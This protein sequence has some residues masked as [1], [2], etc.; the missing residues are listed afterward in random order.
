MTREELFRAVGEVRED[1]IAEAAEIKKSRPWRQAGALAACL[2]LAVTAVSVYGW[3]GR[4]SRWKSLTGGFSPA[5]IEK[6]RP[7]GG[8]GGLDGSDYRT[9]GDARPASRFSEK[10]EIGELAG[11]G[12]GTGMTGMSSCAEW[13]SPEEI[14]AQDTA[15]FRG[16][17][18]SLRYFRVESGGT[19]L[20]YTVANVEITDC[21]RGGLETGEICS[22]LYLGAKGYLTT[23][24][25]GPLEDL[26]VGNEAIFMPVWTSEETGRREGERFFCYADLG[27][28][29]LPEGLRYVFAD[30]GEGLEFARDVYEEIAEAESLDEAWEY[31]RQHI[32]AEGTRPAAVPAESQA[33]SR[34]IADPAPADPGD[35]PDGPAG[36]GENFE[37]P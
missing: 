7:D 6:S 3:A 14:F 1:Q 29:Y 8:G 4:E 18:R 15:I 22:V 9:E 37:E 24:L 16:T 31:L 20:Y 32:A 26:D 27:E 21:L 30:T 34:R 28:F 11:P 23:S 33:A 2:A 12:D 10:V 19:Y 5:V 13:R 17:V 35:P 25:S 36:A